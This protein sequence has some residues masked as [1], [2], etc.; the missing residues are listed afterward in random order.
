MLSQIRGQDRAIARL[1][2]AV[3]ADRVAHAYLF[4]GPVGSGKHATAVAFAAAVN[5]DELP[6]EGCGRCA[7]CERIAAGIHPDVRTLEPQGAAHIIPIQTIRA[8]VVAAVGLPPHEARVRFFLIEE[9]AELQPAA[10]NTLL[11]TLEEPPASTR[12]ILGTAAPDKLL[13]TIRS[14]CQKVGFAALPE[15]LRTEIDSSPEAHLSR[16]PL[17]GEID[18]APG[19]EDLRERLDR[20]TDTMLSALADDAAVAAVFDAAAEVGSERTDVAPAL[21]LL[22][23]KLHLQ[24][25]EAIEGSDLATAARIARRAALVLDTEL[26]VTMHNAHGQLALEAL[27][28]QMRAVR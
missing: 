6:G 11:K 4:A 17:V 13:P 5:C 12:F 22:A 23:E 9:A 20:L 27:L 28:S 21:R 25:R 8:E 10:A 18:S 24:A 15:S 19:G 14:R 7:S 16:G 3:A 26:A 1:R 2:A